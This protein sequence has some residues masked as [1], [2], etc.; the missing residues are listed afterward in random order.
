MDYVRT[1]ESLNLMSLGKNWN[2]MKYNDMVP[3]STKIIDGIRTTNITFNAK[4]K[5]NLS[6]P[7]KTKTPAPDYPKSDSKFYDQP[8]TRENFKTIHK[9]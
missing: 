8:H 5:K 7:T 9:T 4:F 2:T 3:P 6:V 1:E